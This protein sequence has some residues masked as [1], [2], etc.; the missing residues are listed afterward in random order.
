MGES[1][2]PEQEAAI[3]EALARSELS[4]RVIHMRTLHVG[5]DEL[6][7]GVK[8]GVRHDSSAEDITTGINAVEARIRE[9]VPTAR[10]IYIEPD[11]Y[12]GR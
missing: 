12:S 10:I 2:L 9:A 8:V 4:D 1:A 6:L 11:F 3:A 7:V 5:P